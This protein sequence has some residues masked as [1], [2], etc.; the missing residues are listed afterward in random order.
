MWFLRCCPSVAQEEEGVGC[1]FELHAFRSML[2]FIWYVAFFFFLLKFII[3][4][5]TSLTSSLFFCKISE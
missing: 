2:S 4:D 1:A 5:A 3:N